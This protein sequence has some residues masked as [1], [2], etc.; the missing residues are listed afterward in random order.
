MLESQVGNL[1]GQYASVSNR[2]DR[3]DERVARIERRL[4]LRD[5]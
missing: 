3:M 4:E 5:A 1:A 2:L